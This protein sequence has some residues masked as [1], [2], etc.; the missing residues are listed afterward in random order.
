MGKCTWHQACQP[1]LNPKEGKPQFPQVFP[2]F[3]TFALWHVRTQNK[4]IN[5]N[6]ST[7]CC[8]S[9]NFL[10]SVHS[11]SQ[12]ENTL[13]IPL[14][15]TFSGQ[16]L[17]ES[18]PQPKR[19]ASLGSSPSL[20]LP[21]PLTPLTGSSGLPFSH[22]VLPLSTETSLRCLCKVPHLYITLST[23]MPSSAPWY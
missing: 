7:A 4:N 8:L 6:L 3:Y 21:W 17:S 2:D 20:H 16:F 14:L 5:N 18:N 15:K 9:F 12:G 11:L 19:K 13:T 22:P 23:S 1:E 10:H